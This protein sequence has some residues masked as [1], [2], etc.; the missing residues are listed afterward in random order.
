MASLLPMGATLTTDAVFDAFLG[1]RDRAFYYGHTFCGHPL[2]AALAREVL[3]IYRE[4]RIV[5]RTQEGAKAIAAFFSELASVPGVLRTRSLGMIGA[6]DLA[7]S[8]EGYLGEIG[9]R[10]FEEARARGAYLRPL[11][12][13]V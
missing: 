3:A 9:W 13:T 4:E 6:A 10:V 2:G 11:G 5:E 12:N 1:E 8:C 7:S